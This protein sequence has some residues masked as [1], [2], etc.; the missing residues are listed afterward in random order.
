MMMGMPIVSLATTEYA[1]ALKDGHTGFCHCNMDHLIAGMQALLGDH[2][3]AQ[4]MGHQARAQAL[5]HYHINRFIKEWT[6]VFRFAMK[7][8][9]L[10]YGTNSLYQ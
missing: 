5:G 4:R 1:S 3:L 9:K 10:T 6:D 2:S 8:K 7:T